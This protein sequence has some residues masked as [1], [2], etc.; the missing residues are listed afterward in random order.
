MP[1]LD[2]DEDGNHRLQ[3][4]VKKLDADDVQVFVNKFTTQ[5]LSSRFH[6]YREL[7]IGAHLREHGFDVRYEHQI[8]G[9]TPDWSLLN[10]DGTPKEIIDVFTL[11]QRHE[12]DMG[13]S[14]ALARER[15]YAGWITVPP[16]H[17]YRKLS[18]KAGQYSGL[19]K[20]YNIPFVLA[21]FIEF[22][23][24]IEQE[25]LRLVLFDLH[26][27]WFTMAPHVSG[28]IYARMR[29]FQFELNVIPNPYAEHKSALELTKFP[30]RSEA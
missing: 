3:E 14:D 18:D 1:R 26:G 9:K 7:L 27:G 2:P 23:A 5:S 15:C 17:I 16:D 10:T 25:E 24:S 6:T 11:H 30:P 22:N 28:V 20:L 4:L 21:P 8:G 13:I 12:K 29:N 19:T